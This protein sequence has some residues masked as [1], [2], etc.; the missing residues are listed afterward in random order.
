MISRESITKL[1]R[2]KALLLLFLGCL[3]L[4]FSL[5]DFPPTGINVSEQEKAFVAG[6]KMLQ[7][8]SQR[9]SRSP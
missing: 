2:R 7:A 3:L 6:Q 4:L 5:V 9:T 1:I 8:R